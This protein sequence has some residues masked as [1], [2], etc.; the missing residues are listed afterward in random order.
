[1]IPAYNAGKT[2]ARALDSVYAQTYPHIIEV[3]VVDDGST[4]N[5]GEII[6][7]DYPQVRYVYQE[8][9]GVAAARNKGVS[10][11]QG[12]YIAFLD[13][14]DEWLPE[15]IEIQM[16]F[17]TKISG[18]CVFFTA[19]EIICE[20]GIINRIFY[21]FKKFYYKIK[22]FF[23]FPLS[24]LDGIRLIKGVGKFYVPSASLFTR[25]D[26]FQNIGGYNESI[27]LCEDYELFFRFI[28]NG[29][30]LWVIN[31][32]LY[33]VYVYNNSLHRSSYSQGSAARVWTFAQLDPMTSEVGRKLFT[34]KEFND[35]FQIRLLIESISHINQGLLDE[36]KMLL[37][38]ALS[39]G[40][41][42]WVRTLTLQIGIRFPHRLYLIVWLL[43]R[44]YILRI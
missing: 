24:E 33:R 29:V 19:G 11:A 42:D 20:K 8:N 43:R 12:E 3:I 35:A 44:L 38:E 1:M 34:L 27:R 15:K 10:L 39:L 37:H 9:A 28:S 21:V 5:T 31:Y 2:I 25:K 22:Y 26:I 4:D 18:A 13:A 14:D 30:K 32:P 6:K 17:A 23:S 40:N 36:A 16:A 41:Y 7:T